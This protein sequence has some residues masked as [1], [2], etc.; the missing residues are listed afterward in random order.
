VKRKCAFELNLEDAF[1]VFR[2]PLRLTFHHYRVSLL[3]IVLISSCAIPREGTRIKED[4]LYKTRISCG[5]FIGYHKELSGP[6]RNSYHVQTDR[7]I[8]HIMEV[9]LIPVGAKCYFQLKETS[10]AGGTLV[11]MIYFTWDGN[12]HLC[13]I[14]QNFVTGEIF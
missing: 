12:D 6:Y 9:P 13:K 11:W 8:F 10:L 7:A 2:G 4:V 1:H 3:F 14:K 5:N